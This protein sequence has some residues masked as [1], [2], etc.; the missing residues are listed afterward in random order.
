MTIQIFKSLPKDVT[1]ACSGGVDSVVLAHFLQKSGKNVHLAYY[2]HPDDNLNE[3]EFVKEF[4]TKYNFSSLNVSNNV[5]VAKGKLSKEEWWRQNRL[6][7]FSKLSTPTPVCTGHHLDDAIE[8]YLMTA[9]SGEAHYMNYSN[10]LTCKPFLCIRKDDLIEYAVNEKLEW[11]TDETN[12]DVTF[13]KRNFVRS[14]IKPQALVY[15]PGLYTTIKNQLIK[16]NR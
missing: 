13:N 3:F 9:L 2:Q 14:M 4:Y 5:C 15:N 12:F 6:E 16:K 7:F 1:V 10:S 11:F 8:W